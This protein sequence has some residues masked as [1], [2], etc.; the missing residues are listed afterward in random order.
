MCLFIMGKNK[1]SKAYYIQSAKRQKKLES[2]LGQEMTGF[3]CTCND[4]ERDCVREAY[5]ILNEFA[6][7]LYGKEEFADEQQQETSNGKDLKH[8]DLEK[9]DKTKEEGDAEHD[10]SE[11]KQE[12]EVKT[13]SG[14]PPENQKSL[15]PAIDNAGDSDE[16]ESLDIEAAVKANVLELQKKNEEKHKHQR[17]FQQVQCGAKNCVFIR[18]TLKDPVPLSVAIM[19]DIIQNQKQR[20]KRLLRMIPVQKTCKAFAD[21]IVKAVEK[22]SKS[23]F[24]NES[25]TFY[26]NIRI[27]NNTSLQRESLTTSFIKIIQDA[28]SDNTP[29]L[30]TPEVVLN[31]D[32]IKN[33]CYLGFI[34]EY[35]TKYAKYNLVALANKKKEENLTEAKTCKDMVGKDDTDHSE[36]QD[37]KTEKTLQDTVSL[38][39]KVVVDT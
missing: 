14:D 10:D 13:D 8:I 7:Q 34:P 22:L 16:E 2:V 25:K 18:T 28:N 5:N 4:N 35:L 19:D 1:R 21:D 39:K 11:T 17:R 37:L 6:D 3:L 36:E 32:V 30:N 20:T 29:E 23:Y 31:I 24:E 15:G 38:D 9:T 12:N 26:I 33:V 27:R